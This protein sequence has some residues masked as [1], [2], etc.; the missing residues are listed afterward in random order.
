MAYVPITN[1]S[2]RDSKRAR[3]GYILIKV[4]E[5][6]KAFGGWYYEHRLV[7]EADAGRILNQWEEVHHIYEDKSLNILSNLFLC[8][9][10][11]HEKANLAT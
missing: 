1:W 10:K 7:M 2:G 6:P 4:P 5:H 8:V 11:E 3:N 9:R